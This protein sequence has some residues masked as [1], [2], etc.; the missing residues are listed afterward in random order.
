ME[1]KKLLIGKNE[2]DVE[3]AAKRATTYD[4]S[5]EREPELQSKNNIRRSTRQET[6]SLITIVS[7][8][9][10]IIFSKKT[11]PII[12]TTTATIDVS[13]AET[14][15]LSASTTKTT[16]LTTSPNSHTTTIS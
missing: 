14:T 1:Y 13:T 10:W 4:A 15:I 11:E 3:M 6:G 2:E 7:I 8:T 12:N 5:P 9:I 16:M